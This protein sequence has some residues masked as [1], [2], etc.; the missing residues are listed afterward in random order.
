MYSSPLN[1]N[2]WEVENKPL[3]F[4]LLLSLA[5]IIRA[6]SAFLRALDI[7][8]GYRDSPIITQKK[9]EV[10]EVKSLL[11]GTDTS[12]I[13]TTNVYEPIR[14]VPSDTTG[15][16]NENRKIK[17]LVELWWKA[18]RGFGFTGLDH[19]MV[20]ILGLLELIA[21]P[22]LMFADKWSFI[23]AWLG[24]KTISQWNRWGTDRNSFVRFLIGNILV[25]IAAYFILGRYIYEPGRL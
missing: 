11:Q 7:W 23:G 2:N 17:A 19:W 6:I 14:T 24:F 20:G 9:T 10:E 16:N 25:L 8:L 12:K 1:L 3:F 15:N 18:F 13:T 5:L 4:V 21:Y 22:V